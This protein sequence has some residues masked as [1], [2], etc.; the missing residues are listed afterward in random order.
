M[1]KLPSGRELVHSLQD[2]S[3]S[4]T[5]ASKLGTL[6]HRHYIKK[7]LNNEQSRSNFIKVVDEVLFMYF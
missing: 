3:A 6:Q 4:S 1:S 2:Q 5:V 7:I